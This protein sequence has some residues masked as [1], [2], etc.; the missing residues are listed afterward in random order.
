MKADATLG[1]A[2]ANISI[3]LR[4]SFIRTCPPLADLSGPSIYERTSLL[5][6]PQHKYTEDDL[7]ELAGH[8][9]LVLLRA[10]ALALCIAS[11]VEIE[12][13]IGLAERLIRLWT[14]INAYIPDFKRY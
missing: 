4:T 6:K 14:R 11:E 9:S 7:E 5:L 1:R 2:A 13:R 3:S 10:V 12:V 8:R